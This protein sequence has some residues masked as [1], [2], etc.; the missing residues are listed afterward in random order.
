MLCFYVSNYNSIVIIWRNFILLLQCKKHIVLKNHYTYEL[1][2]NVR[3][4]LTLKYD[5]FSIFK[6]ICLR[7][8]TRNCHAY[9]IKQHL[10]RC[11]LFFF[12]SV[13]LL[14]I[15]RNILFLFCHFLWNLRFFFLPSFNIS[16]CKIFSI[17]VKIKFLTSKQILKG[18]ETFFSWLKNTPNWHLF[19]ISKFMHEMPA[20]YKFWKL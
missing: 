14:E 15:Q 13:L 2:Y 10:E 9:I 6:E 12:I 18:I 4:T 7:L 17:I 1:N 5:Y 8:K 20:F 19:F 16:K 11:L 3:F